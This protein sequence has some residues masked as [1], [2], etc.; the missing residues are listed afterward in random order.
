LR[1][2]LFPLLLL[3]APWTAPGFQSGQPHA[4]SGIIDGSVNPDLIP[5]VVAFRLF[6]SAAAQNI[7]TQDAKLQPLG[8]GAA[9]KGVLVQGISDF[10]TALL[11]A[12]AA[13]PQ[14]SLD[15]VAQA[16]VNSLGAKM[17]R[18]GFQT[19]LTYVRGQE[20]YMKRAP[21]PPM[22]HN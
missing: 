2:L 7:D 1:Y 14:A 20:R 9:D 4:Q 13:S 8:L 15:K 5:D 12:M 3:C 19:L 10:K 11:N 18:E 6:F 22:N 17:S 16:A 21:Y